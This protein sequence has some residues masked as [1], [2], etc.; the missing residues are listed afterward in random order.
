LG[1]DKDYIGHCAPCAK[2]RYGSRRAAKAVARRVGEHMVAYR[3]PVQ[4]EFWHTGHLATP[5]IR[6]V[7]PK[8]E[9]YNRQEQAA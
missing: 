1:V 5:V 2:R 6:G 4:Q 9:V 3:C 7:A 8:G